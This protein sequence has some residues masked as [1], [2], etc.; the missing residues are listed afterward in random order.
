MTLAGW[1][2]LAFAIFGPLPL[3]WLCRWVRARRAIRTAE[4][5]REFRRAKFGGAIR[6]P[7]QVDAAPLHRPGRRG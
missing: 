1:L 2:W 4:Q 7:G 5:I 6:K 3:V